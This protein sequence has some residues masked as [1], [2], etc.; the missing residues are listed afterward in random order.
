MTAETSTSGISDEE[1]QK[2]W[3]VIDTAMNQ[4]FSKNAATLSYEELY[5]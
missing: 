5:R 2:M 1:A 3:E 4:I